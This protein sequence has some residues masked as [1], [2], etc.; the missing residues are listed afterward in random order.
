MDVGLICVCSCLR[1][2]L[3]L[4]TEG[5]TLP[6]KP[7]FVRVH[8]CRKPFNYDSFI[9]PTLIF[10]LF[11]ATGQI[12]EGERGEDRVGEGGTPIAPKGPEERSGRR[13]GNR[14]G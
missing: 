9:L 13:R 11:G 14:Y 2:S 10:L 4:G 8:S 1:V 12:V 5:W 3:Y 7:D 6:L